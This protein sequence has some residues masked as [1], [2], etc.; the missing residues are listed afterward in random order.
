M[1]PSD[2]PERLRVLELYAGIGGC[3]AALAGAAHVVAAVDIDRR[4][5]AVYRRNF[6]HPSRV[7]TVEGL[8]AEDL[9]GFR[10]DLWWLSPPC[11]PFTRRGKRRDEDD[12]RAMSLLLLMDRVEEVRPAYVA[13]ENVPGFSGS[14]CHARLVSTLDRAGYV[15]R[16]GVLCPTDLGLPN[17]R[18]RYYLIASSRGPLPAWMPEAQPVRRRGTLRPYLDPE[19]DPEG[20]GPP[21]PALRVDPEVVRRYE[22][23]L[24]VVDPNDPGAV[25]ACFT[26]AYGR[27]PVRSG[28]Y[29][30]LPDGGLRR[31]SPAE[32]LRFLG[33]P[34]T[35]AL[36]ADL[37][38]ERAW[39]LV[40]NSLSIP[41]VRRVLSAIPELQ[42]LG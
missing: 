27:S 21:P 4:A 25:T 11:Q 7:R 5:L 38:P 42:G 28:S 2:S 15:V 13:L 20:G 19:L 18:R 26:A 32:I 31:F 41:A 12:P 34:V 39:P 36:P 22:G 3:A 33:F 1:R 40:G 16:E 35:Y 10:A 23:A 30:A 17:R 29:L 8:T 24:D 9:A 6:T 37:P 14:R